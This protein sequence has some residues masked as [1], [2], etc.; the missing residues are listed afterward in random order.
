PESLRAVIMRALSPD[1][2]RRFP[3]GAALARALAAKEPGGS[4]KGP[5]LAAAAAVVAL[6]FGAAALLHSSPPPPTL[7]A[8][9]SPRPHE[10]KAPTV[11][12]LLAL[13][14][15]R[16]KVGDM[17]G[18]MPLVAR[19]LELD[20]KTPEG[21]YRRGIVKANRNDDAGAI[22]DANRSIELDPRLF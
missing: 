7:P 21:L 14:R 1:P 4:K 16:D 20:A 19:V 10:A 22:E 6:V 15:E 9:P 3:D 5:H 11:A 17:D 12:E 2:R 18:E 13:A 8:P